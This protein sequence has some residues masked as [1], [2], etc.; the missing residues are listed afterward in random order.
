MKTI[1]TIF[2]ILTLASCTTTVTLPD[3]DAYT[4]KSASDSVTT[5]KKGD[6]EI[7]V[8]NRG[9]PTVFESLTGAAIEK[10]PTVQVGGN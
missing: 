1:I 10:M 6:I 2:L 7:S 9:R 5:F 3:G 4:V 8:D